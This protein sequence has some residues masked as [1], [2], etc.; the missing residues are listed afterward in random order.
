ME[1]FNFY[2]D[3]DKFKDL[4][5]YYNFR[6]SFLTN[7]CR[8][9]ILKDA[10]TQL[11]KSQFNDREITELNEAIENIN[12]AMQYEKFSYTIYKLFDNAKNP[13]NDLF[14]IYI[15]AEGDKKGVFYELVHYQ[16][17]YHHNDLITYHKNHS[18]ENKKELNHHI[19]NSNRF[20]AGKNE[21]SQDCIKYIATFFPTNETFNEIKNLKLEMMQ[22]VSAMGTLLNLYNAYFYEMIFI[23]NKQK[24]VKNKMTGEAMIIDGNFPERLLKEFNNKNELDL[25]IEEMF[26]RKNLQ[27]DNAAI[28][29]LNYY[30]EDIF[31]LDEFFNSFQKNKW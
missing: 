9:S 23:N 24:K 11:D 29:E 21:S 4:L 3:E 8:I 5:D 20:I 6:K 16:G 27:Y 7:N 19:I 30:N 22:Y 12:D 26:Y 10:D 28:K 1:F 18:I 17:E 13:K 25:F 31:G 2:S 15:I 14:Y